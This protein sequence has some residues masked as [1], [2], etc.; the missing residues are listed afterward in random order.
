MNKLLILS[1]LLSITALAQVPLSKTDI[2][3]SEKNTLVFNTDFNSRDVAKLSQNA[4][5][6]DAALPSQEPIFLVMYSPAGSIDAGLELIETLTSLNRPVNTLSIF[7]ASMGFQTVQGLGERL[8]VAN[9]T[10]MSHKATGGFSGEFPGQ[11]DSR[12]SYY[13]KRIA[14]LDEKVVARSKGKLTLEKYRSLVENEHWCD[15]EDC[16]KEGLADRVVKASC[17]STLAGTNDV[18]LA[19]FMFAGASIQVNAV[20]SKCPLITGIL[21]A[22]VTINGEN[23]YKEAKPQKDPVVVDY[24]TQQA[25]PVLSKEEIAQLVIRVDKILDDNSGTNRQVIRGY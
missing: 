17:D 7:A 11:L 2:V 25:Q 22:S 9:G 14:R 10:L 21:S 20:R 23:M 16:V 15:G 6:M 5:D 3:L 24:Y 12:Y 13:L 4:R 8:L 1:G 19:K 18:V